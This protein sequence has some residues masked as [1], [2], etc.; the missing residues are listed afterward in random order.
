MRKQADDPDRIDDI[1]KYI[2]FVRIILVHKISDRHRSACTAC[3]VSWEAELA[4]LK[5]ELAVLRV[6]G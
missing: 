4:V 6:E 2:I 5:E 3:V 1:C